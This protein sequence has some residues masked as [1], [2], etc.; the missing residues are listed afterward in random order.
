MVYLSG[1]GLP[2]LSCKKAIINGCSSSSF[3]SVMSMSLPRVAVVSVLSFSHERSGGVHCNSLTLA[4]NSPCW[5]AGMQWI[6]ASHNLGHVQFTHTGAVNYWQQ[7][8]ASLPFRLVYDVDQWWSN[9]M[10]DNGQGR[11]P[12]FISCHAHPTQR[13]IMMAVRT[14][15]WQICLATNRKPVSKIQTWLLIFKSS[16]RSNGNLLMYLYNNAT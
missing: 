2:R 15:Q 16:N 9:C 12:Y 3:W 7:S 11:M 8:L 5:Q 1:A 14:T 13:C 6:T 10:T 4:C